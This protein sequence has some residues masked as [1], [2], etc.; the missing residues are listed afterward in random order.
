MRPQGSGGASRDAPPNPTLFLCQPFIVGKAPGSRHPEPWHCCSAHPAVITPSKVMSVPKQLTN[1]PGSPVGSKWCRGWWCSLSTQ[2]DD[3]PLYPNAGFDRWW[4]PSCLHPWRWADWFSCG[5]W[6][7]SGISHSADAWSP[8]IYQTLM[9]PRRKLT[10]NFCPSQTHSLVKVSGSEQPKVLITAGHGPSLVVMYSLIHG[11][12]PNEYASAP[13]SICLHSGASHGGLSLLEKLNGGNVGRWEWGCPG[14]LASMHHLVMA[15]VINCWSSHK[16]TTLVLS[17]AYLPTQLMAPDSMNMA[18]HA[19]PKLSP[20]PRDHLPQ[21]RMAQPGPFTTT[22][23]RP[24][25]PSQSMSSTTGVCQV[26]ELVV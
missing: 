12:T 14:P 2:L 10:L 20:S 15:W 3:A 4:H 16:L 21:N 13:P 18:S 17:W 6:A 22:S 1:P 7:P 9:T 26:C 24:D 11:A 23:M 19:S 5:L 8:L 25:L